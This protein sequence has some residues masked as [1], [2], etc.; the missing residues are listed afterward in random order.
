MVVCSGESV[1]EEEKGLGEERLR[2]LACEK[3]ARASDWRACSC[4]P[5]LF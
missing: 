3:T 5:A 2:D 4:T 1:V